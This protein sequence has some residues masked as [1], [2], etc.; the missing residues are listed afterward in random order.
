MSEGPDKDSRTEEATEKKISD[1]IEK[2]DVPVSKEAGTF[3]T[4]LGALLFA[5]FLVGDSIHGVVG[6]LGRMLDDPGGFTLRDGTDAAK[7]LH[8]IALETGRALAPFF[9]LLIVLGLAAAF[10]QNPPALVA[11]RIEPKLSRLSPIAGFGRIFG[12]HGLAEFGKA[13]FK[14]AMVGT[15]VAVLVRTDAWRGVNAMFTDP[16]QIPELTLMLTVRLLTAVC[17]A[18]VL[19]VVADLMLVRFQWR[20]DLKMSKQE[21]KD[22]HKQAE[23]DPLVKARMRS[24]ARDRARRRMIADVPRATIVLANPTH[25]AIA[26]RYV[27]EEGGAPVVVA[28]GQDLIALKIREIAETHGIPVVED[29]PLVRSMYDSV[30]IDQQIPPEFYRVVAELLYVFYND[31]RNAVRKV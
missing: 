22:E 3:A 17:I 11:D 21:I 14:L 31:K 20:R 1:A 8:V 12:A 15:V 26:L 28:K 4:M 24:L 16:I 10:F 13:L 18:T 29:K 2:G 9:G 5:A 27:R 6:L 23:G 19:L 30:E 25:Y 7:L